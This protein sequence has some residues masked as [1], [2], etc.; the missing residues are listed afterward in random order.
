LKGCYKDCE[1][2]IEM[3]KTHDMVRIISD[4]KGDKGVKLDTIFWIEKDKDFEKVL[5]TC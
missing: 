1:Q 3:L 5:A 4:E 2:D